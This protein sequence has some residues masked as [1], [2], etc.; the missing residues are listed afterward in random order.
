MVYVA[1]DVYE[2]GSFL[3]RVAS[4][5]YDN[6]YASDSEYVDHGSPL[7]QVIQVDTYHYGKYQNH[8]LSF[9]T[10]AYRYAGVDD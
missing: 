4:I 9:Y 6:W 8:E 1:G 3:A 7:S 2:E 10:S 5:D